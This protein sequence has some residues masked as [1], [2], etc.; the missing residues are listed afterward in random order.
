[1]PQFGDTNKSIAFFVE[2]AQTFD[3]FFQTVIFFIF[4]D[5]LINGQKIF[6]PQ[7]KF[8]PIHYYYSKLTTCNSIEPSNFKPSILFGSTRCTN[9]Q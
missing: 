6:E 3:E 4:Y 5:R 1:M 2:M 9:V 8:F 7:I